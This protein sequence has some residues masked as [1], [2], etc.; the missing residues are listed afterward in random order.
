M[1]VRIRAR[2]VVSVV[3]GKDM[4][5]GDDQRLGEPCPFTLA[6]CQDGCW[7]W[8]FEDVD[9]CHAARMVLEHESPRDFYCRCCMEADGGR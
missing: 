1:C 8:R 9:G 7:A 4:E 5:M 3:R 2:G 6:M